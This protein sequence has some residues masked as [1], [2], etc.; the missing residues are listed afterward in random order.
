MLGKELGGAPLTAQ[1]AAKQMLN[2]ML[3]AFFL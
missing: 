2:T 1:F 3:F